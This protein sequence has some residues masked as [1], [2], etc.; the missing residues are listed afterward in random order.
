MSYHYGP[1]LSD[2]GISPDDIEYLCRCGECHA[3][4]YTAWDLPRGW[5]MIQTGESGDDVAFLCPRCIARR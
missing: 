3:E 1:S 2:Q 4:E 5:E